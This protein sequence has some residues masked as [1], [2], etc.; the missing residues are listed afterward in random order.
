MMIKTKNLTVTQ[1]W[2]TEKSKTSQEF[3]Q[4]VWLVP[5][6]SGNMCFQTY[7]SWR[8]VG[9]QV[10]PDTCIMAPKWQKYHNGA[11][12]CLSLPKWVFALDTAREL[13]G[14]RISVRKPWVFQVTHSIIDQWKKAI[15]RGDIQEYRR[16]AGPW[17]RGMRCRCQDDSNSSP[18]R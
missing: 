11:G 14:P 13:L 9:R 3:T 5:V 17:Q 1:N 6:P 12:W 4:A 18:N 2:H 7:F 8:Q 10:G 16:L 15:Q